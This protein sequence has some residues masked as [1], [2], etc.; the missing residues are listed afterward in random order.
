MQRVGVIGTGHVGLVTAA[1]FADL[2]N[3]VVCQDSDQQKINKL[4]RGTVPIYEPGL[5]SMVRKNLKAKRLTFT[6]SL[7]KVVDESLVI[8]ICVST[9][10]QENGSLDLSSIEN[11]VRRITQS[12]NEYK[13][14]AEKSTVPVET[15][16]RIRQTILMYNKRRIEFSIVSNPEFLREGSAIKDTLHP[17]RIVLGVEDKRAEKVMR[18]LFKPIKA[19]LLIANIKTAEMI[20]HASNS[21]LATK[22]SFI[23]IVAQLCD[24]T[25][26]DVVKVADG[27][28]FDKRI[29]RAFL[30][31]GCGFGGSCFPKDLNAFIYLAKKFGCDFGLLSEAAKINREQK[32]FLVKKVEEAVWIIRG[33]TIGVLGLSFKPDTDDIRFS[34]A[35]DLV[36]M[37]QN[38]GARIKAYDP[39]AM[40][41]A[42]KK[43]KDIK[44][45]HG[46]YEVARNSDCLL[47][48]TEWDEFRNLNLA[49]MKRLLRQP[50]IVD[51]RNIFEPKQMNKL[52]FIYKSIG[53]A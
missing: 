20:K 13:I 43:L 25:G 4:Q 47:I 41:Q 37:L 11:V 45:C 52:G 46:P 9:P 3:K 34:V 5:K 36:R 51:G 40:P 12:M 44:F 26:A 10:P 30:D 2:G 8:F 42:K 38:E 33:K 15:G 16:E 39:Q 50:I 49:R 27:M 19:P 22:I 6:H 18:A 35:I 53:R 14:I 31:A 17:D 29:A 7:P 23:N 32:Q 21:F 28:G 48:M 1:V 24:K